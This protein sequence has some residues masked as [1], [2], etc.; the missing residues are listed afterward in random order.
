MKVYIKLH[1][2]PSGQVIAVCD[3]DL[4]GKV[5]KTKKLSINVST[6]FYK[7]ELISIEEAI[8][9]LKNA[10]NFNIIGSNIIAAVVRNKII[11]DTAILKI[12]NIPLAMKFI[13]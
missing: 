13:I 5:I 10:S 2:K 3:A 9:I 8:N 7:G 12:N 4:L 6:G 11:P 1:N